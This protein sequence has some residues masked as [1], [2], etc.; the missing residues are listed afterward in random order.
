MDT[1]LSTN[2][3]AFLYAG[4]A[5]SWKSKRQKSTAQSTMEAEF[6]AIGV[7]SLE[8][9][10]LHKFFIELDLPLSS[11]IPVYSDSQAA[12]AR[13]RNPVFSESTK[14]IDV[15]WNVSKE[16]IET[17]EMTLKFVKGSE[18]V[19]D[20]LTKSLGGEKTTFCRTGLGVRDIR[21][22]TPRT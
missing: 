14:H 20:I 19:A 1:R 6:V 8:V 16:T 5:V 2:G 17:G 10:W 13:I 4:G 3:Y 9:K 18:N 15:K 11:P 7:A 22:Y 21:P 12:V